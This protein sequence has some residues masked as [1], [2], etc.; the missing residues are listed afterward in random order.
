MWA[1]LRKHWEV[2]IASWGEESARRKDKQAHADEEFLPAALEILER[3]PSPLGRFMFW[4]VVAIFLIA[5]VWATFGRVD[6]VATAPAKTTPR[7]QVKLIQPAELGVVRAIHVENGMAV[8]AGDALIDL[9]PTDA[10][11]EESQTRQQLLIARIDAARSEALIGFLETD[12]ADY[13]P[14]ADAAPA[15]NA[16][17]RQLIAAQTEEYA[18]RRATLAEQLAERRAEL[19]VMQREQAKLTE[20]LPLVDEQ[21]EARAALEAKGLHPRFGLLELQ[22][23]QVAMQKDLEIVRERRIQAQAAINALERQL[24]QVAQEFRRDTLAELADAEAR[25][26]LAEMELEKTARRAGL[27]R[28]AAPVDGVVQQLAVHTIGGVVQPAEPLLVVVPGAG[29]LIVEAS[30][31]NRDIGFVH[32]GD[33]VEVKLEAFPFTKYG[34]IDGVIENLSLDAVQDENLGLIY[35]ARIVLARQHIRVNGREVPLSPGMAATAEVKTGTRRIIEYVAAPLLRYRDE[36]FRE[37]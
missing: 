36:S 16:R 9:D 37:R 13:A 26:A 18:A 25:I 12:M 30:V 1:M 5:L 7:A 22:E 11:A 28:L 32:E 8:K 29:E 17:Q 2:L 35:Q 3:P 10:A 6:V 20:T 14:P 21:V 31:L 33:A 34:V 24:E 19:A 4:F 15:A 23:R 27:R